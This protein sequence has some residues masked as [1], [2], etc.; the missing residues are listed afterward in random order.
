[1]CIIAC[2]FIIAFLQGLEYTYSSITFLCILYIVPSGIPKMDAIFNIWSM[3][4]SKNISPLQ[5]FDI[6]FHV[7]RT[8]FL[9]CAWIPSVLL[10]GVTFLIC[11]F[12]KKTWSSSDLFFLLGI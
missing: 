3:M 6:C 4:T 11:E 1:M 9:K 10:P 2:I 7:E 5:N 8:K 12:R